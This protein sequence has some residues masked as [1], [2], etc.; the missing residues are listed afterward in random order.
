MHFSY[1]VAPTNVT[2]PISHVIVNES[3][4]IVFDCIGYG[5]P[6]PVIYWTRQD[7]KVLPE[8]SEIITKIINNGGQQQH[9]QSSLILN[10]VSVSDNGVI[11]VCIGVNNVTNLLS[12]PENATILL[13][14]QGMH[15]VIRV[16]AL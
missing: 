8:E 14:V 6:L 4:N 5:N 2:T 16:M 3:S 13:T 1:S 12:T 11:F 10:N 15:T 9:V 7:G